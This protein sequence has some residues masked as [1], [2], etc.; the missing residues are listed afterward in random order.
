M[1]VSKSPLVARRVR[2]RFLV[3]HAGA[4]TCSLGHDKIIAWR[5]SGPPMVSKQ[6][7]G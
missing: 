5:G 6:T 1:A 3:S 2:E 7:D 4:G